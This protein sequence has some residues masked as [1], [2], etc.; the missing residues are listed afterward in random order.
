MIKRASYNHYRKQIIE[1]NLSQYNDQFT[2]S[3]RNFAIV[4]EYVSGASMTNLADKYGISLSRVHQ[5][6]G[7]YVMHCNRCKRRNK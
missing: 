6:V 3:S 1:E 7:N 2:F 4:E 5:I